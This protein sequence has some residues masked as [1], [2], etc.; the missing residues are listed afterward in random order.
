LIKKLQAFNWIELLSPIKTIDQHI[1]NIEYFDRICDDFLIILSDNKSK[2]TPEKYSALQDEMKTFKA[3]NSQYIEKYS[4]YNKIDIFDDKK[5]P[6]DIKIS[7]MDNI[8][9]PFEKQSSKENLLIYKH[10]K[11]LEDSHTS[12]S[13]KY[14]N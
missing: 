8:P 14:E 11:K 1:T 2:I 5:C 4:V 13:S 9:S 12:L 10:E 6:F 3:I 7:S